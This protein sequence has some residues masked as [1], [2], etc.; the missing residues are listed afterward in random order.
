MKSQKIGIC[1][2]Q[3]DNLK[4]IAKLEDREKPSLLFSFVRKWCFR[5][6]VELKESLQ[7]FY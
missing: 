4:V 5:L 7:S 3:N 1:D 6:V 2:P